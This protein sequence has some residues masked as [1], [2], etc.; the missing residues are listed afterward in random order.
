VEYVSDVVVD[1][2]GAAIISSASYLLAQMDPE[3]VG[4]RHS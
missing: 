1:G 2:F 4:G 3:Q